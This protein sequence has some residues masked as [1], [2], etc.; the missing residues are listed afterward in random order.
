[1]MKLYV[2]GGAIAGLFAVRAR[3]RLNLLVTLPID[4]V[5]IWE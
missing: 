4:F 5:F 1:M 2:T 3:G